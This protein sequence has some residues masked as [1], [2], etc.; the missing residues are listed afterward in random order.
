MQMTACSRRT[1]RRSAITCLPLSSPG[2][3]LLSA[4]CIF[5]SGPTSLSKGEGVATVWVCEFCEAAHAYIFTPNPHLLLFPHALSPNLQRP[6]LPP[7]FSP[8]RIFME[9]AAAVAFQVSLPH[10]PPTP[11][12]HSRKTVQKPHSNSCQI[13]HQSPR[14]ALLPRQKFCGY[15]LR[16]RRPYVSSGACSRC[17]ICNAHALFC[18]AEAQS[19][20]RCKL[21]LQAI[22]VPCFDLMP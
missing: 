17:F 9:P 20:T 11:T 3:L 12:F 16:L 15:S 2:R 5:P 1:T 19:P 4:C 18:R 10:H 7:L 22:H 13:A 14:H 6:L 8:S 21:L